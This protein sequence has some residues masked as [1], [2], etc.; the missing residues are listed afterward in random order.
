M[1]HLR[2]SSRKNKQDIAVPVAMLVVEEKF[3]IFLIYF[4][5]INLSVPNS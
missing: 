1:P 5:V 3:L 4:S 2:K